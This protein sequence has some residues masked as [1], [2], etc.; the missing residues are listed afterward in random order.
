MKGTLRFDRPTQQHLARAR[1]GEPMPEFEGKF[2]KKIIGSFAKAGSAPSGVIA[3]SGTIV[4]VD[5]QPFSGSTRFP[6]DLT[7]FWKQGGDVAT[8]VETWSSSCA[9][10]RVRRQRL[11]DGKWEFTGEIETFLVSTSCMVERHVL[12]SSWVNMLS[13]YFHT[14][15]LFRDPEICLWLSNRRGVPYEGSQSEYIEFISG[16]SGPIGVFDLISSDL[17]NFSAN[18][19]NEQFNQITAQNCHQFEGLI[20]A[21]KP[22]FS[23]RNGVI[24]FVTLWR[25]VYACRARSHEDYREALKANCVHRTLYDFEKFMFEIKGKLSDLQ[26]SDDIVNAAQI[27]RD[28]VSAIHT[29]AHTDMHTRTHTH[30][31]TLI[32]QTLTR[33][34]AHTRAH[35]RA[36]THIRTHAHT[37]E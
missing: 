3:V 21:L 8:L 9:H 11:M 4:M 14:N 28:Y 34:H 23:M 32:K 12:L 17:S 1:F 31:C 2:P 36:L 24:V 6:E 13:G 29:R 18:M 25:Q 37:C 19:T 30:T 33:A 35:T 16:M 22:D 20:V 26:L 10:I 7:K 15:P 27:L 5:C